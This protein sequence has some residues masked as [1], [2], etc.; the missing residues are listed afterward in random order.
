M[1]EI[2]RCP[3]CGGWNGVRDLA[4][5]P[6][7]ILTYVAECR[8][9]PPRTP[10]VDAVLM[11]VPLTGL[12]EV[13]RLLTNVGIRADRPLVLSGGDLD[14]HGQECSALAQPPNRIVHPTLARNWFGTTPEELKRIAPLSVPGRACYPSNLTA[15]EFAD[16]LS[17]ILNWLQEISTTCKTLQSLESR[18]ARV[19]IRLETDSPNRRDMQDIKTWVAATAESFAQIKRQIGDIEAL[20]KQGRLEIISKLVLNA[21]VGGM[22]GEGLKWVYYKVAGGGP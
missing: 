10:R 2:Q 16:R 19:E 20:S 22:V 4:P 17:D 12:P 3:K 1:P 7:A 15:D 11:S 13:V 14:P 21:A 8:C 18:L 9:E 6:S 5:S